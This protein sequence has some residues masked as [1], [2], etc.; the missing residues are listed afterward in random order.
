[1]ATITIKIESDEL[2][3]EVLTQ[4]GY[5]PSDDIP[6]LISIES[7]EELKTVSSR[8]AFTEQQ[9]KKVLVDQGLVAAPKA[10]EWCPEPNDKGFGTPIDETIEKIDVENSGSTD[11][12]TRMKL[13][14]EKKEKTKKD[15]L[16]VA[17]SMKEQLTPGQYMQFLEAHETDP[18]INPILSRLR[19]SSS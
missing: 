19:I 18:N 11:I 12:L 7:D 17:A 8:D 14:F 1:M 15:Y 6:D 9:M 5:L 10:E 2:A 3:R 16:K 4:L 13:I